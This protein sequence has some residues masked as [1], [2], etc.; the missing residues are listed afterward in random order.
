MLLKSLC[1]TPSSDSNVTCPTPRNHTVSKHKH[2]RE[3]VMYWHKYS[4]HLKEFVPL[5]CHVVPK[6]TN[7]SVAW[8]KSTRSTNKQN[9]SVFLPG[10]GCLETN[11]SGRSSSLPKILTS[12]LWKSFRGS[13]TFPYKEKR[14]PIKR[15]DF[16]I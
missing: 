8:T 12:S 6:K 10:K 2:K 4:R 5:S 16:I 14:E 13:I 3:G 7:N 9:L 15:V 11:S 1:S